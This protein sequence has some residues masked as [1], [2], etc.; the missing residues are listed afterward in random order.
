MSSSPLLRNS[1]G[2]PFQRVKHKFQALRKNPTHLLSPNS[3]AQTGISTANVS[4]VSNDTPS[5]EINQHQDTIVPQ[6][7]PPTPNSSSPDSEP[8]TSEKP[9]KDWGMVWTGL[10]TVLRLLEK[11]ADACPPLKSAAGGLVACLD[12]T[13]AVAENKEEYERLAIELTG[14]VEALTPYVT[15]LAAEGVSGSLARIME[16]VVQISPLTSINAESLYIRQRQTRGKIVRTIEAD[17]DQGDII[18]RYHRIESLFRQLQATLLKNMDPVDDARYNSGYST[19][20]GRRGCTIDMHK[21]ILED[22]QA[23]V[24]DSKE[25][26]VYWM[27]GTMGTGK[28]TILYSLCEWLEEKKQLGGNYFCSRT[29]PQ[30]RNVNDIVPSLA[31]QLSQYSPA[32]RSTLCK[33]LEETPEAGKLDVKRQLARLIQEPM[34]VMKTAMPENVI[35]V[36]DALDECEDC[37]YV[38]S[39]TFKLFLDTLLKLAADL[40]LKFFVSSRPEP[41]ICE[42]M[43]APRYLYSVV[44]LHEIEESISNLKA[45]IKKYLTEALGPISPPPSPDEVE[46]LAKRTGK[47]L[48]YAETVVRYIIPPDGPDANSRNR[49]QAVLEMVS[50]SDQYNELDE[51]HALY[52]VILSAAVNHEFHGEVVDNILLILRTVVCAKEPMTTQM[53]ASLLGITEELVCLSLEPLQ[54]LLQEDPVGLI[55]PFHAS[56]P[57]FLFDKS[58]S[59]NFHCETT[60]CNE[61]L[62]GHCFD[63]MKKELKFNIC[64][65]ESSFVFDKDVP[66]LQE[67]IANSV[68][69]TLSYACRYWGEHLRQG[70]LTDMVHDKLADF[71]THRLLFWMEVLNLRQH[72]MKGAEI[73]GRIQNWLAKD[74]YSNTWKQISDAKTFIMCFTCG[75]C[76]RSTPH[77]Y[78]SALPFCPRTSSVYKNYRS[79][80]Q[81]LTDVKGITVEQ[82]LIGMWTTTSQILSVAFSPDSTCIV[83]GSKD[84]TIRVWDAH[85]GDAVTRPFKGHRHMVHSVAFSHDGTY[86]VS[87]SVDRTIRVWDP[88]TGDTVVEPFKGHTDIVC[89]VAFAPDGTHIVSGSRD[90]TVRVWNIN[91]G[92]VIAE[93]FTGH[94]NLVHSV[95]FSPDGTRIVS[96]SFDN[97]VRVWDTYTGETIAGPFVEHTNW[98]MSVAFSPDGIHVVSGSKDETVRVWD[99]FTGDPVGGPFR[100]HV[101]PV[102]S[103]AFSP[104]G[105]CVVS[106]SGDETI[107]V[108]NA[109]TGDTVAGPFK[110]HT[111]SVLS[112]S[113][114]P[115]GT[116]IVSGSVDQTIRVWDAHASYTNIGLPKRSA[117]AVGSVYSVA[118]SAEGSHIVSGSSEKIVQV[119]DAGTGDIVLPLK[120]HT[121]QIASVAF[122]PDGTSIISSSHD[123]TIRIW[124]TQT[125][126]AVA[127]PFRGHTC[128]VLSIAF[129][130]DG[131]RIVSGSCDKSIR[132]WDAHTGK[133]VV[134]PLKGHTYSVLSVAISPNGAYIVSCSLERTIRVWDAHTGD[135]IGEPFTGH[136][137]VVQSVAFSP[138][139][140][141]I[142]SGSHDQ[143]IRIWDTYTGD[144]IAGPFRGHTGPVFS[145]AFSPNGTRIVSGS[146]D[147]TIRVWNART[148][149]IVAGPFKGHTSWVMSVAFS[150]NGAHIVS[151]SKDRTIRVWDALLGP[152]NEHM[153]KMSTGISVSQT[154]FSPEIR[155]KLSM[156]KITFQK[157]GW[158][159]VDDVPFL[160][161]PP[162]YCTDVSYAGN[163]L[164]INAKGAK[165]LIDSSSFDLFIGKTWSRCY[166]P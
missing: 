112:V 97:T 78:I 85:T 103:V 48:I 69:D 140:S 63:I 62:A 113:F 84:N 28:T 91:T 19:T 39:Y 65:L 159:I 49:L 147:Q 123:K 107:R 33:V 3:P 21:K 104:D 117:D 72:I 161:I 152:L 4:N 44:H 51:L 57:D 143:T 153:D 163:T 36:I 31:Y 64:S 66:D 160:W 61:D 116:Y 155:S 141:S 90:H 7:Y 18:Q 98:V 50:E 148:G 68:S 138:D 146:W 122:S 145:V 55:A 9:R 129:S 149:H 111:S 22:L 124:D 100:G 105:A 99:T 110:G 52:M 29:S 96:G 67:R 86:V 17:E 81:G 77:I 6:H 114:S 14:T 120:G 125:G 8:S 87:G 94:S 108:W 115:D 43:L 164:V 95:A 93:P 165:L 133:T 126:N 13:Q 83:S 151:G 130:P 76:A 75:A 71:I 11:S 74:R 132:V 127:R 60:S 131:T 23:W 34:Q 137:N 121:A 2:N 32:F 53:I 38:N 82:L 89:S 70:N 135:A 46:K 166:S 134:G 139:G 15:K 24:S 16:W 119:W 156:E 162:Q 150:P 102:F 41:V 58:I 109:H 144:T 56:F 47:L 118:F 10:I 158:L 79:H 40:P 35:V 101:G 136:S 154:L 30:C 88:R 25:S 20:I 26:K 42:K 142:V 45:D 92:D 59:G 12:L 157:D 80:I 73:L 37:Q 54:S 5:P 27:N 128:L 1:R 106:G